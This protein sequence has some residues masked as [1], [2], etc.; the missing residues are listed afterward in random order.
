[1][2]THTHYY[3]ITNTN[4]TNNNNN[5]TIIYNRRLLWCAVTSFHVL[6][7]SSLV[8]FICVGPHTR[9]ITSRD[10]LALNVKI[11]RDFQNRSRIYGIFTTTILG[12]W[13][14]GNSV[15]LCI[16][17]PTSIYTFVSTNQEIDLVVLTKTIDNVWSESSTC[18]LD[19]VSVIDLCTL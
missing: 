8:E 14:Q 7:T 3:S 16:Y 6:N 18:C 12:C 2:L 13:E 1:M 19:I 4:T 11:S 15:S 10:G 9:C 5:N 17:L